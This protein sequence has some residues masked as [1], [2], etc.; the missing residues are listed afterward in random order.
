MGIVKVDLA[1]DYNARKRTLNTLLERAKA[2]VA[3]VI[4]IA[5]LDVK[6]LLQAST[7]TKAFGIDC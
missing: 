2:W 3:A 4:D 7:F 6:G 5:P 1:D